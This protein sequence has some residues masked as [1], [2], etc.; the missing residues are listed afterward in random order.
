MSNI[1]GA[2]QQANR[3]LHKVE[4]TD[5]AWTAQI[6]EPPPLVAGEG[7]KKESPQAERPSLPPAAVHFPETGASLSMEKEMIGLYQSM[8]SL[9]PD[10]PRKVIQFIGS[11]SGEGVSTIVR[12]FAFMAAFRM[13]KPVL[14]LDADQNNGDQAGFFGIFGSP[15]WDKALLDHETIERSIKRVNDSSLYVSALSPRSKATPQILD[16][17]RLK[18]FFALLKERFALVLIDSS[19]SANGADSTALSRC[20]DG[21]VLVVEADKTR[22]PVAENMQTRIRKSGG[23]I[24][25]VVFNKR[26]YYIPE[27]IYKM[28]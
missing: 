4:R 18:A 26:R 10:S 24:L 5:A 16:V 6:P 12:Q 13:G 15:G 3:H 22:W 20:A 9:L 7:E 28:L 17:S 2:L 11:R 14:I 25:G 8:D 19:S 1:Y 27:F 23:N 21:V